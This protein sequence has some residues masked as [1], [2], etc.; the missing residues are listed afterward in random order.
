MKIK[1][2]HKLIAK[3]GLYGS[4]RYLD[5]YD[6][7]F[8]AKSVYKLALFFNSIEYTVDIIGSDNDSLRRLSDYG[9][10]IILPTKESIV[11]K[12]QLIV[13]DQNLYKILTT[14]NDYGNNGYSIKGV[15]NF[16][17]NLISVINKESSYDRLNFEIILDEKEHFATIR[18]ETDFNTTEKILNEL[19]DFLK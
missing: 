14:I 4:F 6:F 19:I 17:P 10:K 15:S 9:C 18:I 7:D 2:R 5:L 8:S 13:N 3:S 11:S 16:K 12:T 1:I